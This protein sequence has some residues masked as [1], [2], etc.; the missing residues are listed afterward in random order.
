MTLMTL[1]L[2]SFSYLEDFLK[3]ALQ[4]VAYF[5][6]GLLSGKVPAHPPSRGPGVPRFI[7]EAAI[8]SFWLPL[9]ALCV[10]AIIAA[11]RMG[12]SSTIRM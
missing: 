10:F 3:D 12:P 9:S 11:V 2:N 1:I 8:G 6:L 5:H 4:V 7:A